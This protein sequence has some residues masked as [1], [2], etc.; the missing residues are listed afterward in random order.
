[1]SESL[2]GQALPANAVDRLPAAP[3]SFQ[4]LSKPCQRLLAAA[5]RNGGVSPK[6]GSTHFTTLVQLGLLSDNGMA[7]EVG[8]RWYAERP[9]V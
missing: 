1:M 2:F 9:K 4:S 8:G 6:A 5:I 7:T 3:C